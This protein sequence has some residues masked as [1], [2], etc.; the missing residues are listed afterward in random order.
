[1]NRQKRYL[2]RPGPAPAI[3]NVLAAARYLHPDHGLFVTVE[4]ED[5]GPAWEFHPYK[6]WLVVRTEDQER[7][8]EA[9]ACSLLARTAWLGQGTVTVVPGHLESRF[10]QAL[11]ALVATLDGDY[12]SPEKRA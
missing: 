9:V 1:M 3:E 10:H 8:L 5:D 6:R 2:R 11:N 4:P 7:V 12:P